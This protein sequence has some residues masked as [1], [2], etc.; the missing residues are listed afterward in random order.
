MQHPDGQQ[1]VREAGRRQIVNNSPVVSGRLVVFVLAALVLVVAGGLIWYKRQPQLKTLPFTLQT[2]TGLMYLVP[3][4]PTLHGADNERAVVPAFYIDQT[5]VTN[6]QYARFCSKTGHPLPPG[7]PS[8]RPGYPA[9]NITISDATEFASWAGKRL[10]DPIEWEK[11]ARG[12]RGGKY[13]WGDSADPSRAN[14]S[15]NPKLPRELLPADSMPQYA[16]PSRALH[17]VGNAAEFVRNS[18]PPD[19]ASLERFRAILKPPPGQREPWFTIRGGSYRKTLAESAP[20]LAG[21]VPGRY[22]APD[23]GF[24]CAKDPDR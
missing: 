8:D 2:G 20:W 6:A 10:P 13:P 23:I 3:A 19:P 24:R 14:V 15:D 11:A 9:V 21:L 1:W 4:G 16:S 12:S 7:F 18:Y 22:S 5:E 17:M